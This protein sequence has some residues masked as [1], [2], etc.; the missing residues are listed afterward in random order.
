MAVNQP[1]NGID[2]TLAPIAGGLYDLEIDFAGDIRTADA[3][4]TAILVSLLADRRADESEVSAPELRRG[5]LG[6]EGTDAEVGSKLWLFHQARVTRTVLNGVAD[7]VRDALVWFVEDGLAVAVSNPEV[8]LTDDGLRLS[9][10]IQRPLGE[11]ET[12]YFD[13]WSCTG[14]GV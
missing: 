7:A 3:F 12:R 9:I 14:V 2:A 4:D 11:A 13:L 10:T 5:W 6:N 1:A 8:L